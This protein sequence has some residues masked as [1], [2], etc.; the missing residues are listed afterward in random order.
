MMLF[1]LVVFGLIYWFYIGPGSHGKK[2]P[3]LPPIS[4]EPVSGSTGSGKPIQCKN[5]ANGAILGTLNSYTVEEVENACK[6][7]KEAQKEWAKTDFA[8]RNAV[9]QDLLD[10][11]V[12]HRDEL[13]RIAVEDS[14]KTLMEAISGEILTTCEKLRW[15]ILNGARY[16]K[17]EYRSAPLLLC[18]KSARVEYHPLGVVAAIVPFN[19]PIHNVMSA[20]SSILFS[21]NAAVVKVSEFASW[22]SVHLSNVI[23]Q[24]LANRGHSP[25]LVQIIHG[26]GETGAA[27]CS[28]K[29]VNKILFI[30]SPETGS[31]VMAAAAKNLTPVILELGGKDPFIVLEDADLDH[32]VDVALRGI[33]FNSGQN[34]LAAERFYVHEKIY[35]IFV[36]RVEDIVKDFRQGNPLT[37]C[38]DIGCMTGSQ[39]FEKLESMIEDAVSKGAR[40]LT[41]GKRTPES[42]FF[43]PTIIADASHSMEVV[44]EEAFGPIMT[45]IKFKSDEEVVSLA[46]GTRYGLGMSIFSSNYQRASAISSQIDSGMVTIND[47]GLAYL[48]QS[49]PFGG[50]KHSGFSK[51]NGIEGLREF[52]YIKTIVSDRFGMLAKAPRFVRFPAQAGSP[53]IMSNIL[54]IIYSIGLSEKLK[55]TKD[56]IHAL[57]FPPVPKENSADLQNS[58][59]S[60][61]D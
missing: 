39:Q 2:A 13:A 5:P 38:V 49:L 46:N 47:F 12:A 59:K 58:T 42:N 29:N 18:I 52:T 21:G 8:E 19:Y 1:S 23:K 15:M 36:K 37:S 16:L 24:I 53:L 54:A 14:G 22:S 17:P 50:V 56:L 27:L 48:I 60:K 43:P 44:I 41:G 61:S 26:Y 20:V 31:K 7:A 35:D 9:L 25:D 32:A 40:L 4:F 30:G 45:I 51:F 6:L 57:I 11:V 28:S 33:F 3:S 10:Y 55:A 34:C